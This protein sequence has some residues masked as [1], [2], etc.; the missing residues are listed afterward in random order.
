LLIG[1]VLLG[2]AYAGGSIG[3]HLGH[4]YF[5]SRKRS[6]DYMALHVTLSGIRGL[7]APLLGMT[8]Y[9]AVE[10]LVPGRGAWALLVPLLLGAGASWGFARREAVEPGPARV[11]SEKALRAA[12]WQR[13]GLLVWA[14]TVVGGAGV[15]AAGRP[16]RGADSPS[17][18]AAAGSPHRAE[19]YLVYC[20]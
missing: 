12:G 14:A 9:Q 6:L 13:G 18:L 5:S 2:V 15:L 3:F 1:A 10:A 17:D 8:V 4:N 11:Q 19:G 20:P 16:A 7:V